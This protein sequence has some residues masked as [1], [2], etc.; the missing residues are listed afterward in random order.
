MEF[1]TFILILLITKAFSKN[2]HVRTKMNTLFS[3]VKQ[4]STS[5]NAMVR[6]YAA[7]L[8]DNKGIP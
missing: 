2:L 6:D 5:A 1:V 4:E 7:Y 8:M 3:S